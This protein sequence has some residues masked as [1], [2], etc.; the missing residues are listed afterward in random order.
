MTRVLKMYMPYALSLLFLV[1]VVGFAIWIIIPKFLETPKYSVEMSYKN[2]ELRWYKSFIK[3]N[4]Y[5]EGSQNQALRNGFRPLVRFIGAKERSSEK[6][7]MTVPV[8]QEQTQTSKNWVV[9]FSMPSKYSLDDI[10]K[11]SSSNIKHELVP[12]KLM[13][14]IQFSGRASEELIKTK[15]IELRKWLEVSKYKII[16]FANYY[17]YNDPI[18]P[19][20]FRKNEVLFEVEQILN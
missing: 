19:G 14:V 6:I 15:E 4:V 12:K 17:F 9:S 3:T 7:S 18:T 11:P 16:G 20:I 1:L 10:P 5:A 8:M 2:F 13:A